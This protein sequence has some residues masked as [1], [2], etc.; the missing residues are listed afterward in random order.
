M[1]RLVRANRRD[2]KEKNTAH[3]KEPENATIPLASQVNPQRRQRSGEFHNLPVTQPGSQACQKQA[4]YQECGRYQVSQNPNVGIGKVRHRIQQ[5]QQSK[6]K[7]APHD[8]Q[9]TG[10]AQPI[11]EDGR[12][13]GGLGGS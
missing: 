10:Q 9:E 13:S 7:E 11:L 12:P 4:Y 2:Q 5:E 1:V 3:Q 8:D 6:R